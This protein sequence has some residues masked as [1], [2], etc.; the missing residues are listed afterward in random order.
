MIIENFN[1][2]IEWYNEWAVDN[3]FDIFNQTIIDQ[4]ACQEEEILSR[5][6]IQSTNLPAVK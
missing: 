2:S 4:L 1:D 3:G 6:I 5:P